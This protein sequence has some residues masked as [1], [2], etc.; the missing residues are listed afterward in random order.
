MKFLL[1]RLMSLRAVVVVL[2]VVVLTV[3]LFV[4][5]LRPALVSAGLD[6]QLLKLSSIMVGQANIKADIV[7]IDLP[8]SEVERIVKEPG[9]AYDTIELLR[10][11]SLHSDSI[12]G[13]FVEH[14]PINSGLKSTDSLQR[15]MSLETN[16]ASQDPALYKEIE[17]LIKNDNDFYAWLDAGTITPGIVSSGSS[18]K[19]PGEY[20]LPDDY[21]SLVSSEE[22]S[23]FERLPKGV[24]NSLKQFLI[25]HSLLRQNPMASPLFF[26][27]ENELVPSLPLL[28]YK[29][30]L[31]KEK[32]QSDIDLV[33]DQ[34]QYLK[35]ENLRMPIG[36]QGEVYPLWGGAT[37]TELA[38]KH[39]SLQEALKKTPQASVILLAENGERMAIDSAYSFLS[40]QHQAYFYSPAWFVLLEFS[41]VVMLTI[42]LVWIIPHFGFATGLLAS[43]FIAMLMIVAQT[44]WQIAHFQY[45]PMGLSLQ[46]LLLGYSIMLLWLRS[47][48]QIDSLVASCHQTS[49]LLSKKLLQEGHIDDALKCMDNC[50]TCDESL[51]LIYQ[52]AV[53]QEKKRQYNEAAQTY[54]LLSIRKRR[55]KDA[56]TRAKKLASF[57][58]GAQSSGADLSLTQTLVMPESELSKP[59]LG[60]YEISRELGRGAM[61]VVYLGKDPKISRQVAI[62]TLSYAQFDS[63]RLKEVKQR[64]LRE[65]EAA[66]RLD[67][68]NIVKVFDVGEERDLAYIAMDYALG[69]PLSDFTRHGELLAVD[70]IYKIVADVAEALD[71]AHQQK[72]VHRDIKPANIIFDVESNRVKV[73]DFGIARLTDDSKTK[74]GDVFGSPLYMAPE[75]L[76]GK[77]VT[78][79]AD[80]YSLGASFYQLLTG[81]GPFS[82]D[83]LA[84]LTYQILNS[85]HKSV[86]SIRRDLPA[87]AC[88]IINKALQKDPS[89]RYACGNEMAE[90]LRRSINRDFGKVA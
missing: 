73:S 66:G 46:Y 42:F 61:G 24:D 43:A 16:L 20:L 27:E 49:L 83:S 21:I 68:P 34:I 78:G 44:A 3:V 5:S 23:I 54:K 81:V 1:S 55:Y 26:V 19:V 40:L 77:K 37:G 25:S 48:K 29:K 86:R 65:A 58:P 22:S 72:V 71:Y 90:A 74:T 31:L 2:A 87:S 32:P 84:N 4:P 9:A 62:K 56:A 6:Q 80:I 69:Q 36:S 57:E 47:K 79:A 82:G 52:I 10:R 50:V 53:E 70:V 15:L 41:I 30:W 64:F 7:I 11:L 33:W 88:R 51:S 28:I 75:Q 18:A 39:I 89:K 45:L 35:L 8:V 63:A 76:K 59:V 14:L 38:I 67:H 13:L 12:L 85:K 60:R 17:Q